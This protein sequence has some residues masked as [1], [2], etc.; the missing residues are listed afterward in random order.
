MA[1][2]LVVRWAE[3]AKETLSMGRWLERSDASNEIGAFHVFDVSTHLESPSDSPR[4][5]ARGHLVCRRPGACGQCR[6]FDGRS[7]IPAT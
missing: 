3:Y 7:L 4:D 6:D 1:E 2:H 5:P